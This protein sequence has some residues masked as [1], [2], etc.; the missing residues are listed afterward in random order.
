MNKITLPWG[1]DE[2]ID[3]A[4][5]GAWH[6]KGILEPRAPGRTVALG[7]EIARAMSAPIGLPLLERFA[8]GKHRA[9]I[10]I[11]DR[12]RPT[13][14]AQLL[15]RVVAE[16]NQA[17]IPDAGITVVVA[18]GTHRPMT[19]AEM[20]TRAGKDIAAR[21]TIVNHDFRDEANLVPAG[22]T[23]H[24]KIPCAYNRRVMDADVIVSIGCIE[25]H[26]TAGVG[27]GYK[28]LMP[29]VSDARPIYQTHNHQ[30]QRPP[31][32][33]SAGMP[34]ALC[35][36]RQAVDEC[37]ALL[38]PRVFIVNAV[39]VRG[40]V[41]AV[42]A[43]DPMEAHA[44]GRAL[45]EDL[46]ALALETGPAD[47]VITDARPLDLDLRVSFKA[48]FN[49]AAAV[50][51]GG[52]LLCVTRTPEG[53][54]DLRLPAKFPPGMRH[55]IKRMPAGALAWLASRVST[56]SPDQAVGTAS[57]LRMIH[58]LNAILFLTSLPG[59]PALESLGLR[60]FTT[61]EAIMACA[62][63]VKPKA[64][65]LILPHGGASFIAWESGTEK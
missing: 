13:P 25:A 56:G 4:L 26:E 59:V 3:L 35:R 51:P 5:P 29:G 44:A 36:Y 38:G 31:R 23:P 14:V 33:S 12:T 63:A 40:E 17:G 45:Y 1:A 53:L 50:K 54:G 27:G 46:S 61:P 37:G 2:T 64:E 65:V 19:D 24:F 20:A 49:A 58:E 15:P 11:D 47:V 57:L 16:L 43:G 48:C 18:L 34:R 6:V 32:I 52:M 60:F 55:L 8:Q 21:V 42:V 30:F 7:D 41:V 9:A 62:A 28:N 10:V 39:Y 22:V